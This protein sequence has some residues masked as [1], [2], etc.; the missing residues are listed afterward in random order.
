MDATAARMD[1]RVAEGI[2]PSTIHAHDQPAERF[3]EVHAAA[4]SR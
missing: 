2:V 1:I 3:S 4:E